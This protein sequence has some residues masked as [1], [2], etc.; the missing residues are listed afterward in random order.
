MGLFDRVRKKTQP[1]ATP[2]ATRPPAEPKKAEAALAVPAVRVGGGARADLLVKPHV[3]EKAATLASKGTY[4]FDVPMSA[5]KIEVRKAVES[6][7]DVKVEAVRISR[8][9][10]K[11]LHRGKNVG[12]R[13]RW[14]KALVTLKKGQ[15]LDLYEGV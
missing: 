15:S 5:N 10:G 12:Q 2:E 14:K 8:G 11:I 7:Y 13:A 3:S 1:A 6:V 9:I 4:V